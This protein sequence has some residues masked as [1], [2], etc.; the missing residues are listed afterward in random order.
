M[1]AA[2]RR[3]FTDLILFH[4]EAERVGLYYAEKDDYP[5]LRL[6]D[7]KGKARVGLRLVDPEG[8]PLIQLLDEKGTPRAFIRSATTIHPRKGKKIVWPT[9]S[10]VFLDEDGYALWMAP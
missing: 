5:M 7:N 10:M 6:S 1:K 9:S 3:S 4:G 8:H 2:G